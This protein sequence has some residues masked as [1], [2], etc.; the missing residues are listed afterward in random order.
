MRENL[1]SIPGIF[2]TGMPTAAGTASSGKSGAHTTRQNVSQYSMSAPSAV[3]TDTSTLESKATSSSES[4]QSN[5]ERDAKIQKLISV[6]KAEFAKNVVEGSEDNKGNADIEKYWSATD[7]LGIGSGPVPAGYSSGWA[8]CAAFVSWC[9]KEAGLFSESDRPKEIGAKRFASD[10]KD[11]RG[12]WYDNRGGNKW[13]TMTRRPLN[14]YEGDLVVFTNSHIGICIES[15]GGKDYCITIEGNTSSD[16]K[17]E[18]ATRVERNGGG[19]YRKKR[20]LSVIHTTLTLYPEGIAQ[21]RKNN[22]VL[23]QESSKDKVKGKNKA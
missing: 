23:A 13:C 4:T 6:A 19:L 20:P 16:A 1:A 17:G 18:D 8:W 22:S 3:E 2:S 5:S 14:V 15:S 9:I 12:N 7:K 21:A 11:S 10:L